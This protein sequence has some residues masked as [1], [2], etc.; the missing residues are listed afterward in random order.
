MRWIL[1][2]LLFFTFKANAILLQSP[3]KNLDKRDSYL[4]PS[5][6]K[7]SSEY[8]LGVELNYLQ[9]PLIEASSFSGQTSPILQGMMGLDISGNWFINDSFSIGTLIP[10]VKPMSASTEPPFSMLGVILEARWKIGSFMIVPS[11]QL[12]SETLVPVVIQGS[13]YSLP[14]GAKSG[15]MGARLI[16]DVGDILGFK[17]KAFAGFYQA[18]DNKFLNI[19]ETSH[20]MVGTSIL[21]PLGESLSLGGD[22]LFDKTPKNNIL[23]G[24]AYFSYKTPGFTIQTGAG[25]DLTGSGANT[26]KAFFNLTYNF[27]SETKSSKGFYFPSGGTKSGQQINLDVPKKGDKKAPSKTQEENTDDEDQTG[28]KVLDPEQA[29]VYKIEDESIPGGENTIYDKEEKK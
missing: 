5:F 25:T 20:S 22:L 9:N 19:D 27:G 12:P 7:K 4:T 17:P 1:L 6:E 28:P 2:S 8:N 21:K 14:L 10:M 26:V 29:P 15:I 18:P 16:Y 11:Y 3:L 23:E 24:L 13:S